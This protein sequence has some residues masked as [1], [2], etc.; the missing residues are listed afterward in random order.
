MNRRKFATKYECFLRFASGCKSTYRQT[1]GQKLTPRRK[2]YQ[3][4]QARRDHQVAVESLAS[5]ACLSLCLRIGDNRNDNEELSVDASAAAPTLQQTSERDGHRATVRFSVSSSRSLRFTWAIVS[6][7]SPAR[8]SSGQ[9]TL[10][11]VPAKTNR[12]PERNRE[13]KNRG[14]RRRKRE[15]F[16]SLGQWSL[17]ANRA[18]DI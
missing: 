10:K 13:K 8:F 6:F 9:P 16:G 4:R 11:A 17:R 1:N 2:N 12:S 14:R 3:R 5:S 7:C 15:T 18:L